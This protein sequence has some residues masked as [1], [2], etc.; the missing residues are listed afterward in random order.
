M[1]QK[2]NS[3]FRRKVSE[4]EEVDYV[5]GRFHEDM[6]EKDEFIN[7]IINMLKWMQDI[8]S[9]IIHYGQETKEFLAKQLGVK[10]GEGSSIGSQY[11]ER[12][13]ISGSI[14]SKTGPQNRPVEYKDDLKLN[15]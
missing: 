6:D 1:S 7:F 4:E 9:N 13:I 14:F 8:S 3:N 2:F 12:N 5:Q 10:D 15:P 11:E